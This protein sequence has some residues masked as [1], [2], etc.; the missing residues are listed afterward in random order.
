MNEKAD[1]RQTSVGLHPGGNGSSRGAPAFPILPSQNG[2]TAGTASQFS[3]AIRVEPPKRFEQLPAING[4]TTGA[5][6]TMLVRW[7]NGDIGVLDRLT[8][9]IYGRLRQLARQILSKHWDSESLGSTELVHEAYLKLINCKEM[10]WQNRAHFFGVAARFM[11]QVLVDDARSRNTR[12]RG[13]EFV[14][15]SIE[16]DEFQ[17]ANSNSIQLI[18]LDDALTDLALLDP[19][20]ARMV[21]LRFFA[22]MTVEEAAEALGKSPRTVKREWQLAKAWLKRRLNSPAEKI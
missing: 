9:R 10:D 18:Q 6:T 3:D 8:E 13:R 11:R 15:V 12:K 17:A 14:R 7:A 1:F 19:E 16:E 21:E 4:D 20:Q 2:S 5:T 22:G